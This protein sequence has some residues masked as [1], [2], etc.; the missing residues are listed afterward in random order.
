MN[1]RVAMISEHANPLSVLGGVDAGGQ[2]VYIDS[3]SRE[4]TKL[5]WQVDVFTRRQDPN[6]PAVVELG[7][8]ARVIS[9]LAGPLAPIP[10]DEIWRYMPAFRDQTRKFAA[11]QDLGYNVIH[12]NFW[13]SGWAACE[14]G[15]GL[16]LPVVQIFHATGVT[17]LR[18]QGDADTSPTDRIATER[19]VVHRANWMIAQC[20]AERSELLADYAASPERI[21]LIP[22][23]V[24]TVRFQPEDRSDARRRL[25]LPLDTPLIVYVGRM[26]PRKDVRNI[27]RALALLER[28]LATAA[29]PILVLVGGESAEPDSRLTPEIG[30]LHDLSAELGVADRVIFAGRR[31]PDDL[32]WWYAAAD[33]VVTTPWYEPFGLTP[34]EAMACARPVIGSDVG[35][36][37]FTVVNHETGELVPPRDAA[38]LADRLAFLLKNPERARAMGRAGRVRVER[39]F[40]WPL[41]A[42]RTADLYKRARDDHGRAHPRQ[43]WPIP[44]HERGDDPAAVTA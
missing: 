27:V 16:N 36:I 20:P 19:E 42:R 7:P 44:V 28:D 26:Q 22:S 31:Q 12:G 5:G 10:K 18:E 39:D 40:T 29:Q 8:G 6:E 33:V 34:L 21:V 9:L 38:A 1:R 11:S 35:G 13:M 2:N 25:G 41:V 43:T 24:D 14:L 3:V 4:L 23:A 32:R 17:K 37:S 15:Q 30:V